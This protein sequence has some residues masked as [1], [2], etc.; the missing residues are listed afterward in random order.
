M[1]EA[2]QINKLERLHELLSRAIQ[3]NW[4]GPLTEDKLKKAELIEGY[5]ALSQVLANLKNVEKVEG[6]KRQDLPFT[7]NRF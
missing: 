4:L 6:L 5:E 2:T 3:E 1:G 7:P